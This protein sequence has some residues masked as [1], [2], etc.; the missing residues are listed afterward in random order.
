[1]NSQKIIYGILGLVVGVVLTAFFM[2]NKNNS[3]QSKTQMTHEKN[4]GMEMSMQDMTDSLKGKT[5]DEFDK[6]FISGM[7][8]HHEGAIAMA[9][10]AQIN[11]KHEEIKSL[12]NEIIKAQ[13]KEISQMKEWQKSWGYTN[14]N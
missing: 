2:S 12:A 3:M 4:N 1:M 8:E 13:D 11:G 5:G 14:G 6:A 7:I 10:D 9:K